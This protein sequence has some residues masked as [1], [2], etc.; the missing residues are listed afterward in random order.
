LHSSLDRPVGR[1]KNAVTS[2]TKDGILQVAREL[3]IKQGYTATSM[4]QLAEEAGIG[5]ATI[6]HHFP[7]KLSIITAILDGNI[8]LMGRALSAIQAERGPRRR[9]CVAAEQTARFLFQSADILRVVRRE[10]SSGRERMRADLNRF[11][12]EYRKLLV[13]AI[14]GGISQGSFRSVDPVEAARVFMTMV[15]G[16]FAMAYLTGERARSP[17]QAA[18]SLLEIYFR[19]IDAR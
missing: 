7:D 14:E 8:A 19:G 2:N 10:V 3:F 12:R 18:S 15:Q 11:L 9:V 13:E 16:T 1:E 6:Y 5:K 4:R 17:E